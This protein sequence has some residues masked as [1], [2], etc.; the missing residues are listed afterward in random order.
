MK[1]CRHVVEQDMVP[2]REC[3]QLTQ[4]QGPLLALEG[5]LLAH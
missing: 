3:T 5:E 2:G 1:V 4:V